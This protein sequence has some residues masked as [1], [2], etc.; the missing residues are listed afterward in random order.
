MLFSCNRPLQENN[1][2]VRD[3]SEFVI[4]QT[5]VGNF[6]DALQRLTMHWDALI[7]HVHRDAL[8]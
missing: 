6:V 5:Y 4:W 2:A 3:D 1:F 8:Q 7:L